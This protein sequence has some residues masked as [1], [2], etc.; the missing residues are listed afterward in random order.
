MVHLCDE[1]LTFWRECRESR[2]Q[3]TWDTAMFFREQLNGS[4]QDE[5]EDLHAHVN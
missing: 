4:P 3:I 1:C 5:T 2:D